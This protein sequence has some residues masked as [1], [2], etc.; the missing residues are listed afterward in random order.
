[1]NLRE[2]IFVYLD[3]DVIFHIASLPGDKNFRDAPL[4][5]FEDLAILS[6]DTVSSVVNS[7]EVTNDEP[8][9]GDVTLPSVQELKIRISDVFASQ[10]RAVT[11][12]DYKSLCYQMPA[13]FGAIKL[14]NGESEFFVSTCFFGN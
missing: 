9:T 2:V 3:F 10:N 14:L 5:E 1:M 4:V 13:R 12:Q 6:A 8:I 11:L 7:L